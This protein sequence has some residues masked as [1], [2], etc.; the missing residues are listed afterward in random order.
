MWKRPQLG[1]LGPLGPDPLGTRPWKNITLK[2][3]ITYFKDIFCTFSRHSFF[4]M[5]SI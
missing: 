1:P 5:V 2:H 3:K 4:E